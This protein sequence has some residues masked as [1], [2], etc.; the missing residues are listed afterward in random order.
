MAV[1][2]ITDRQVTVALD[3]WEKLAARRSDLTV[4]TRAITGV[5]V[6]DDACGTARAVPAGRHVPGTRIRGV[7]STGTFTAADG[8]G[9]STFAVCHGKGPGIVLELESATVKRIIISTPQAQAYARELSL[10]A[11]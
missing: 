2:K 11:G 4:P 8:T 1:L 7:T 6:V 3:W 10:L 9:E 5:S